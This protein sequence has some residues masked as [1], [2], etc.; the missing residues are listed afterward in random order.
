[1]KNIGSRLEGG[2]NKPKNYRRRQPVARH[3]CGMKNGGGVAISSAGSG[4]RRS[5]SWRQ[6]RTKSPLIIGSGARFSGGG[7]AAAC[8]AKSGEKRP[9]AAAYR[10]RRA[11]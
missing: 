8:N 3:Q 11:A 5:G 4:M 9:S 10:R 2:G 6:R 7:V 1:M